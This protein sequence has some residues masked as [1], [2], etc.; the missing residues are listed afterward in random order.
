MVARNDCLVLWYEICW[1]NNSFFEILIVQNF[2][3]CAI[4]FFL[5]FKRRISIW[6]DDHE[7][8]GGKKKKILDATCHTSVLFVK[9]FCI[10]ACFCNCSGVDVLD[11]YVYVFG[12]LTF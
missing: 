7:L 4:F 2:R 11:L 6:L 8:E 1:E 3:R 12:C 9:L 5:S 10:E